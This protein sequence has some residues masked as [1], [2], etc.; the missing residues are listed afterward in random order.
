MTDFL[1][2][3]PQ[4]RKCDECDTPY[5]IGAVR[6]PRNHNYAPIPLSLAP[7]GVPGNFDIPRLQYVE[8]VFDRDN[9]SLGNQIVVVYGNGIYRP[10]NPSHFLD[11]IHVNENDDVWTHRTRMNNFKMRMDD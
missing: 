9:E 5:F 2:D 8:E 1:T 10:H 11:D 4:W 6:N 3:E 7:D